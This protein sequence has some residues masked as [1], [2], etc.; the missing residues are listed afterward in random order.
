ML[1]YGRHKP[2]RAPAWPGF[3]LMLFLAGCASRQETAVTR[4]VHPDYQSMA[5]STVAVLP[6]DNMST[7]LDAT[8]LIRPIVAERLRCRGYEVPDLEWT[9]QILQESGVMV[10]HDVRSFTAL[11]L[12]R[13]LGT[14]AVMFGMV[15]DFT[16]KYAV[17]YASVAVQ[18]RLELVDCRSGQI[19]W[20]N[21][22]RAAQNTGLESILT[23]L[24]YHDDIEK[25]LEVVAV[26]N[27]VWAALESYRPYAEEAAAAILA[28]LPPG[29]KGATPC[30]YRDRDAQKRKA[31]IYNSVIATSPP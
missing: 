12:G 2:G 27:A 6:F 1:S 24:F 4:A 25:G 30:P 31:L 3:L 14:D 26:S 22:Q 8:P 29:Y 19:L 10:S 28:S 20:Q 13:M 21:E 17:V 9:D 18:L 11:E 5:P 15:T 16:T 7:D 23:L